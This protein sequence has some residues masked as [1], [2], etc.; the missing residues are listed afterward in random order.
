MNKIVAITGG[1]GFVG[2]KV[3]DL[4]KNL[5]NLDIIFAV[6]TINDGHLDSENIRYVQFDINDP[7]ARQ[8]SY[9]IFQSPD[10]LIN[11]AW[12]NLNDYNSVNHMERTLKNQYSFLSNMINAGLKT[13]VNTGTCLEY[14]MV[15]G[16]INESNPT[17]PNIPY[18]LAK[19]QLRKQ[20]E[21]LKTEKKFN[22][23]WLRLFYMYGEG[24]DDRTIFT[25]FLN[26]IKSS[27]PVFNMSGGE[28]IRDYLK[29]N[30]VAKYIVNIALK[31]QDFGVINICSG[32][33]I[34]ISE[35]V[36][37]W[38]KEYASDIKLNLGY[39]PYL[40]HEPMYFWGSNFKLKFLLDS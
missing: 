1:G 15:T 39:Y 35:L 38:R 33:P 4:L 32:Q 21:F 29:V 27:Q 26:A 23:N 14:G 20:L 19:D 2:Q 30:E 16:L 17:N 37:N 34:S 11:L 8:N 10:I 9:R 6:R 22:L 13:L 31:E 18:A 12:E 24:Q 40:S 28:Q 25:Q 5:P 36:A 7:L 3:F